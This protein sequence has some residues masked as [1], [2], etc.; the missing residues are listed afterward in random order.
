MADKVPQPL[1][2]SYY[3]CHSQFYYAF[4]N[5]IGNAAGTA[6]LACAI[7]LPIV[8]YILAFLYNLMFRKKKRIFF[9]TE[10]EVSLMKNLI[11]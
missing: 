11:L 6:G 1:V 4:K 3:E 10:K 5:N 8:T 9:A 2:Y 7:I